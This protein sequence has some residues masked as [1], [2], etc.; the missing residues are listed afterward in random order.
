[1]KTFKDFLEDA[2]APTMSTG[3]AIDLGEPR[4]LFKKHD[5]R[6]RWDPK[7]LF[8]RAHGKRKRKV[9]ET[10]ANTD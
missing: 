8:D 2:E 9:V 5:R 6:S 7:K 1:M 3:P 4:H 10:D